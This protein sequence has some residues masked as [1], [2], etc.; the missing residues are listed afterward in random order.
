MIAVAARQKK[1]FGFVMRCGWCKGVVR[2]EMLGDIM[3]YVHDSA[4]VHCREVLPYRAS[5]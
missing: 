5:R 2:Y 1:R 3:R 4:T